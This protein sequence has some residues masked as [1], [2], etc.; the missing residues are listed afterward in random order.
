MGNRLD[1]LPKSADLRCCLVGREIGS[2]LEEMRVKAGQRLP[3]LT[4]LIQSQYDNGSYVPT[5]S[6]ELIQVFDARRVVVTLSVERPNSQTDNRNACPR[7]PHFL[8]EC[9]GGTS[10]F[11]QRFDLNKA[12]HQAVSSSHSIEATNC[13]TS[14]CS[15][16]G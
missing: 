14:K 16:T 12:F 1:K 5:Y 8:C 7:L 4:L 2:V 10:I 11:L 6:H 15:N 13:R 3:L 9:T